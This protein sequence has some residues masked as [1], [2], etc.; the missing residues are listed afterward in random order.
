M[1]RRSKR[2]ARTP[3]TSE[4]R[5]MGTV[6]KV[7][8][9]PSRN[10]EWLSFQMSQ[11]WATICIQVP[12]ADRHAPVHMRRKSRYWNALKM[13]CST[14]SDLGCSSHRARS[15]KVD[16]VADEPQSQASVPRQ[17]EQP[18]APFF[19]FS[20]PAIA[21]SAP[22]LCERSHAFPSVENACGSRSR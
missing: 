2:S 12:M 17:S 6:C 16:R 15:L 11:P 19:H 5:M 7:G 18:P 14:G 10:G 21:A 8:S 20:S 4:K 9:R 22:S 13:R 1:W 3:P